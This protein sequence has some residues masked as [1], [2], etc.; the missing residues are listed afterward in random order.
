MSNKNSTGAE[1]KS[2]TEA[3]N[4]YLKRFYEEINQALPEDERI[5]FQ[6]LDEEGYTAIQ[7]G[8]ATVGIN[9]LED[10]GI[11]MFISHIMKVPETR[12]LELFRKLLEY[13]F[14]ATSDASFAIDRRNNQIYL[15]AL[16][17]LAGLDYGEFRD[18]LET[19]AMVADEFD[20]KLKEEFSG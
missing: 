7:K 1:N 10:R 11:L 9:V 19:V 15:R 2:Y 3:V 13:N 17:G 18:M 6:L 8:S 16:R 12:Q 14:L 20:D 4:D 5:R